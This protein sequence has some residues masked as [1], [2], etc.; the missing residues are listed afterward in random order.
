MIKKKNI[1][2]ITRFSS[3]QQMQSIIRLDEIVDKLNAIIK[4]SNCMMFINLIILSLN[5]YLV[6]SNIKN[7]SNTEDILKEQRLELYKL[8][9]SVSSVSDHLLH[10]STHVSDID[11]ILKSQYPLPKE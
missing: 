7:K 8:S 9:E 4:G 10:V 11:S 1:E 6:V 5:V 2:D 3:D